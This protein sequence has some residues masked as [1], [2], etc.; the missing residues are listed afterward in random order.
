MIWTRSRFSQWLRRCWLRKW[1]PESDVERGRKRFVEER[2][3]LK[4]KER[5][6]WWLLGSRLVVVLASCGGVGG[7]RALEAGKV[8][9]ER[10]RK[11]QEK[12]GEEEVG[13][14][15]FLDPIFFMLKPWNPHL[16]IRDGKRVILSTREKTFGPWFDWEGFQPLIQ[17]RH[18]ELSNLTVKGYLSWPF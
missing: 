12:N 4:E 8:E 5:E 16:F 10:E 18:H 1:W 14:L 11:W 6:S 2:E 15:W 13:F 7:W 9:R 17:S 3:R